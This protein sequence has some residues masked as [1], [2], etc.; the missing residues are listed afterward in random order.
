[1]IRFLG[2][3]DRLYSLS[4]FEELHFFNRQAVEFAAVLD[5]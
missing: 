2:A 1:V 5:V 4:S 3:V